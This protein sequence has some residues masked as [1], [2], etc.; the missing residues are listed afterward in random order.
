MGYTTFLKI[1]PKPTKRISP[2]LENEIWERDELFTIIKY[3]NFKRNKAI[4]SLLWDLDARSHEI[5]L[6]CLKNIRLKEEYGGEIPHEAKTGSG[7]LLLTCSFPYVRNWI[8]EHPFRNEPNAR[9]VCN[10]HNGAPLNPKTIWN[11]MEHLKKRISR[12]LENG[13]IENEDGKNGN[14]VE[15]IDG[16]LK[17]NLP[18]RIKK[19]RISSYAMYMDSTSKIFNENPLDKDQ[20]DLH[21][22]IGLIRCFLKNPDKALEVYKLLR[23]ISEEYRKNY[24][25]YIKNKKEV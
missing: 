25:K 11:I 15:K 24:Y 14:S 12:L 4:I 19:R 6:L 20:M 3:E 21:R 10:L 1:K 8:N 23:E 22:T 13:E 17:F 16:I 2:Y 9:L 7:P 18:V 5:T